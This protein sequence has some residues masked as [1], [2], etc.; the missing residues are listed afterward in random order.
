MRKGWGRSTSDAVYEWI[1]DV[2]EEMR[3][4][5]TKRVILPPVLWFHFGFTL[6]YL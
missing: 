4:N 5:C 2:P 3:S 6:F 1:F